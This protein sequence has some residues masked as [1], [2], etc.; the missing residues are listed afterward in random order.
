MAVKVGE[1]QMIGVL[2]QQQAVPGQVLVAVALARPD[3]VEHIRVAGGALAPL[4]HA[5]LGGLPGVDVPDGRI[6]LLRPPVM[7]TDLQPVRVRLR[8][9]TPTVGD[10][11]ALDHGRAGIEECKPVRVRRAGVFW[12]RPVIGRAQAVRRRA[13]RAGRRPAVQRVGNRRAGASALSGA[14]GGTRKRGLCATDR[15][16]PLGVGRWELKAV[17]DDD[18]RQGLEQLKGL[19]SHVDP[20]L[21]LGQIV[22]RAV[23]EAVER[24]DPARPPRG[25]R[26]GRRDGSDG[27]AETSAPKDAT[28]PGAA[29]AQR[30]AMPEAVTTSAAKARASSPKDADCEHA[31]A[32]AARRPGAT[33]RPSAPK[34]PAGPDSIAPSAPQPPVRGRAIPSAVK[35]QVWE[36]DQGCCSYVDRGRGAA[37]APGICWRSTTS[38][39]SRSAAPPSR[40]TCGCCA[41]PIIA[42]ATAA[43][44]RT[45][46]PPARSPLVGRSDAGPLRPPCSCG[47]AS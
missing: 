16:R 3:P 43:A 22:G 38:F 14:G 34:E 29:S 26:T 11:P 24:H 47:I 12:N 37:A 7:S 8:W 36:R 17:I 27:A 33:T 6:P 20:H 35:R 32:T 30:N 21:T 4:P 45:A 31:P 39:R 28:G 10:R 19:L 15:I 42:T 1:F 5:G 25:R 23:R 9:C 18:C 40:T 2:R 44:G 13:W 46:L 41:P